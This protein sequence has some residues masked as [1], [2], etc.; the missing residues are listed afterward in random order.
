[1]SKKG[2]V[3]ILKDLTENRKLIF[4]LAKN[5]FKTQYAGSYL[6]IIWAFVQPVITIL[7]YWFV[8]EK[9]LRAGAMLTKEGIEAPFVLWLIAGLVPWFF[10]QDALNGGTN[11][12]IQYS[13]LVKKVVF[14]ISILP[15]VKIIS[16]LFVHIFFACFAIFLYICYGQFSGIYAVQL[17]YYSFCIFVLVLGIS[18]ASCAVVG[19]FRDLSQIINIMLQIG[20][21]MTPIMWNFDA[22]N[23]PG[24]LKVI[25]MM[26][27]MYYVVNG[28]R[29]A[30]INKVWFWENPG[31]TLYFW[32]FTLAVLFLGTKVF[33]RLRVHFADVL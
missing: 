24:F 17:I 18:Y 33:K 4:E 1:M 8:F 28:Y 32:G 20:M 6:G 30:L 13:Y 22:V 2:V 25:L 31:L 26:N 21:W 9:G 23:L 10:F 19:F 16:S 27:P 3:S 12:L 7:L 15:I 14:K 29:D 5:D 11:A